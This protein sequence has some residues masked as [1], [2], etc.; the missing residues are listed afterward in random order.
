MKGLFICILSVFFFVSSCADKEKSQVINEALSIVDTCPDSALIL[1]NKIN[2][3]K[4]NEECLAKYSLANYWALDKSGYDVNNDS[5]IRYAFNFYRNGLYQSSLLYSRTMYYMGKYF[6]LVDSIENAEFCFEKSLESSVL[7]K[8]T[9]TEALSAEK[10]SNLTKHHDLK[11]SEEL[12][13]HAV[14]I[15]KNFSGKSRSNLIWLMLNATKCL[16]YNNYEKAVQMGKDAIELSKKI[17]DSSL[18]SA[19]HQDLAFVYNISGKKEECLIEAK[20]A[21]STAKEKSVSITFALADAYHEMDSLVKSK[22]LLKNCEIKQGEKSAY[23]KYNLLHK[24]AIKEGNNTDAVL[25]ADSAFMIME[26]LYHKEMS[27][28]IE[29]FKK[30]INE[31]KINSEIQSSSKIKSTL[32]ICTII[33]FVLLL[34][35]LFYIYKMYRKHTEEKMNEEKRMHEIVMKNKDSQISIMRNYVLEKINVRTNINQIQNNP[36][37]KLNL[38]YS[39]WREIELF[40]DSTEDSF[41]YRLKEQ[42]KDLTEEDIRLLMLIKLKM[43]AKSLAMLYGISEQSIKHKLFIFKS[44]IGLQESPLSLRSFIENF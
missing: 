1:L 40:L 21:Y 37:K 7:Q 34:C 43:S 28:K 11:K 25:Y 5:L 17:G 22:E 14:S 20:N 24:I 31:V 18:I 2:V 12:S 33:I 15:Y 41:V 36:E 10:L 6:S 32:F 13:L 44:K 39:D 9:L 4:L 42:Y 16:A 8:D 23:S 26:S 3:R 30:M 38:T 35:F 29:Y 19:A 27:Y